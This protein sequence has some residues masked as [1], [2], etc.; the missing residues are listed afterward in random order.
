MITELFGFYEFN[1]QTN[2]FLVQTQNSVLCYLEVLRNTQLC[3]NNFSPLIGNI[4]EHVNRVREFI[5]CH[6]FTF[7]QNS[8]RIDVFVM[9]TFTVNDSS[10]D[11]S[12]TSRSI[13]ETTLSLWSIDSKPSILSI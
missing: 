10:A 7:I 2:N 5:T 11:N 12:C 9:I 1:D 3:N 8:I 4:T 13:Y 6:P